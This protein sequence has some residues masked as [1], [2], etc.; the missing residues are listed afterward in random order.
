MPEPDCV[1]ITFFV[2]KWIVI[3][4]VIQADQDTDVVWCTFVKTLD[5]YVLVFQMPFKKYYNSKIYMH[6]VK[7]LLSLWKHQC[8]MQFMRCHIRW[9]P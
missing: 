3:F 4:K 1:F 7:H 5:K 2:L 6:L 9:E 8:I